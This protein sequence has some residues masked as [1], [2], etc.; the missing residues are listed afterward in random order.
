MIDVNDIIEF[1][2]RYEVNSYTYITMYVAVIIAVLIAVC[3]IQIVLARLIYT[4]RKP[5]NETSKAVQFLNVKIASIDMTMRKPSVE[6]T[7]EDG[8]LH[9]FT[10]SRI[11]ATFLKVGEEGRVKFRGSKYLG[12]LPPSEDEPEDTEEAESA[13]ED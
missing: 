3:A 5:S 1:Y 7:D 6:F 9:T 10:M 12:F 13:G 4:G 11:D 2:S 8:E